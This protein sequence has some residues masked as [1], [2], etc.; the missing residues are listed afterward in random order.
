MQKNLVTILSVLCVSILISEGAR[1][2]NIYSVV[3]SKCNYE[4]RF[5]TGRTKMDDT[6]YKVYFCKDQKKL[7]SLPVGASKSYCK[8]KLVPIDMDKKKQKCPV[9]NK[10]HMDI[11]HEIIAC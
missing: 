7:M 9:C 10:G 5:R 4:G 3:C 6:A 8:T 11:K 1:A 2:A